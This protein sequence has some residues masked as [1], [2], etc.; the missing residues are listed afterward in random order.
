MDSLKA[1][2]ID[3]LGRYDVSA[4]F[5]N[6]SDTFDKYWFP[7]IQILTGALI[8]LISALITNHLANRRTDSLVEE[9]RQRARDAQTSKILHQCYSI[10]NEI[11]RMAG[12]ELNTMLESGGAETKIQNFGRLVD[13]LEILYRDNDFRFD[14]NISTA[15]GKS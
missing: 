14:E 10:I 13:R 7:I 11:D 12:L 5:F 2:V 8:A 9:E 6:S 3:T 4:Q 1:V 15:L